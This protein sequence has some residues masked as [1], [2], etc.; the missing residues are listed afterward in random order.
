MKYDMPAVLFAGGKSSRMGKD[1]ALL[2]FSGYKTLSQYQ[3]ERLLALFDTVYISAKEDKFDFEAD[4][5]TDRYEAHSPLVGMASIFE[6]LETEEV[7]ILSVDAPFVDANV[8]EKLMQNKEGHDVVIA[9]SPA[10]KQPLCGIYKRSILPVAQAH[11]EEDN[12]RIGNLLKKVNTHLVSFEDDQVFSNL[13][14]PHEY[15]EAL[16][17]LKD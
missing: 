17:R 1:K 6:T 13:N 5:I 15:E 8:I 10:G 2:P 4:I 12:H 11:I 7:F 9:Q 3:V 16:A 14:H